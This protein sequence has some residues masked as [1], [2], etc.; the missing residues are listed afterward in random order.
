MIKSFA[1]MM[2][3]SFYLF[4]LQ[5]CNRNTF[6]ASNETRDHQL[7]VATGTNHKADDDRKWLVDDGSACFF[8]LTLRLNK[9]IHVILS[10]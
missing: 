10:F 3:S 7:A 4:F 2:R 8:L 9:L 6:I 1:A 5:N